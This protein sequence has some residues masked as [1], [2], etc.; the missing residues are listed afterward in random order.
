MDNRFALELVPG[1]AFVIGS[2]AGGLF[3]GAGLAA[4]ATVGAIWLRWR[5]DRSLP[6]LA[7]AIFCTD[8]RAVTGRLD[9]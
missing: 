1:V 3:L 5:W 6:W 9:H 7:I 4:A 2:Y 8:L